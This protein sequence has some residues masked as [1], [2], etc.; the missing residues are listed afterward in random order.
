MENLDRSSFEE[1][2]KNYFSSLCQYAFSILGDMEASRDIVQNSFLNL[3]KNREGIDISKSVKSYLYTSVRN[4]SINHIRN[5]KKFVNKTLDVDI[6]DMHMVV[7]HNH[8][9]GDVISNELSDRINSVLDKLPEKSREIFQLNRYQ[10][11][12][13]KDISEK[14]EISIK[15]VEAHMSKVLKLLREELKDYLLTFFLVF[16]LLRF[17]MKI[18]IF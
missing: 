5:H 10:G 2:F 18:L 13:Y 3:W 16:V 15:T 6:F 12:K 4:L 1:L 8:P 14:L 11:M 7:S 9:F 17:F